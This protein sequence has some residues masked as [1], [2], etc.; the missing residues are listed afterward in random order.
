MADVVA[1][2][3]SLNCSAYG[4]APISIK[5]FFS[6][7]VSS[8]PI[9]VRSGFLQVDTAD[10]SL[11]IG[12]VTVTSFLSLEGLLLSDQGDYFCTAINILTTAGTFTSSS[13]PAS[14]TVYRKCCHYY[15]AS[16]S[17]GSLDS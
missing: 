6:D 1:H 13:S 9:P 5:W 8:E 3:Q 7:G 4:R 15:C 11:V 16:R 10:E 14:V 17:H 12:E 2:N